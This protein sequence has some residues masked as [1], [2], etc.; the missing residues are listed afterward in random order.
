MDTTIA[1]ISTGI[2]PAGIAIIRVSGPEAIVIADKIFFGKKKLKT[3]K[4]HTIHYG[5][6]RDNDQILDEVLCSVM[7]APHTFT[8][9][10][11]VEVNCHGGI[12]VA[13]KI[14]DL[15]LRSG[16]TPA[17]P[18]EFTKRAFLNGRMDLSKAEAVM[19]VIQAKNQYA[20]RSSV[21]HLRGDVSKK[22]RELR[23]KILDECAF[24]EAALDDPEH[25][26]LTDYKE[27]LSERV[28]PILA[29][30]KTLSDRSDYGSILNEGVK[31][32][33]A[34]RPNAGKSSLLNLLSGHEK[35]IVTDI[36]G[37][38]RDV[39]EVSV[40]LKD[41]SLVLLDTAGLRETNDVVEKIGVDR[42]REAMN[43]AD[44][45][46]Y[47]I[48]GAAG[49][50]EEDKIALSSISD[51]QIL[52]L[53]NKNDCRKYNG[54]ASSFGYPVIP[55][56]CISGEGKDLLEENILKL[57]GTEKLSYGEDVVLSND[58]QKDLLRKAIASLK[59]VKEGI[60]DELSEEFLSVDLVNAYT[61]LG[62]IIGEEVSDDVINRVFEKFCMG[63]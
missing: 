45:V 20:L 25:Y 26:D 21:S 48:D 44:L 61:A 42:A 32:V 40:I 59:L 10:D 8:G 29:D 49:V 11:T 24:I 35:A 60:K 7:K 39:L 23:E 41:I 27:L 58:R 36:A 53:W 34:G 6:I 47:V 14:L 55:F 22:V 63:K 17:E 12:L 56:S 62:E 2:T 52:I 4:T 18:G 37:T 31:T 5:E 38:T 13:G 51:K 50:T 57:F 46:L 54:E 28:E 43:S 9:E 16:A 19:E 30:L 15:L 33:I 3:V 1:A